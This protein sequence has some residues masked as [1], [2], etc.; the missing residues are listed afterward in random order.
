MT[1]RIA[2]LIPAHN[3]APRIAGVLGAV[4]GHPQIA[5]VLV[6]DDGSG[7]GTAEAARALGAEVLELR[8]NRGKT[9]ALAAGLACLDE[10][11]VL[12][13]DADLEGLSAGAISRL[14]APVAAGRADLAISLRGNAPLAW[15]AI[16]LDYISGERVLPR[17][18]VTPHLGHLNRLPGFGFEVFLNRLILRRGLRPAIVRWPE[19]A[20]PAKSRKRGVWRGIAADVAMLDDMFRTIPLPEALAQIARLRWRARV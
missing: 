4:L 3:E 15:R 16:G 7:D 8:P 13:L 14:I 11:H 6:V 10:E 1:L 12:L 19:V 5:R 2:C 17:A 20:S 18:L 9:A